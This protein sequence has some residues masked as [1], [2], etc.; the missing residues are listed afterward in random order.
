MLEMLKRVRDVV[1]RVV[2]KAFLDKL[3]EFR[4]DSSTG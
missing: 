3:K 4:R 1:W 2:K